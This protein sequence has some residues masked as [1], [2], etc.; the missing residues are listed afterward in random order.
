MSQRIIE[1]AEGPARLSVRHAQLV[2]ERE[3]LD[4]VTTPLE[5]I[6][7][8]VLSAPQ[9]QVTQAVLAGVAAAG[10]ITVISGEKHLPA[11]MVLPLEQHGTQTER[12]AMQAGLKSTVKKRLWQELVAAKIRA[13]GR[14]LKELHGEDGG[15][16]PMAERVRSGDEGNLEAQAARRYWPLLFRDPKFRR[17]SEGPDQNNHLNYGYAVLRAVVARAVCG[18]GLHP[19]LGVAHRNRYNPFCLADDVME[20][21]RPLVDRAAA[22]WV[23]EHD[24]TQPLDKQAKAAMIQPT[25]ARYVAEGEE[26]TLFDVLAGVAG[27]MARV[28]AGEAKRLELPEL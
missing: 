8:L 19:S 27:R 10:G 2:V 1:I 6:A 9:A 26:R 13:Q 15:L 7:A 14:L 5:E 4:T 22:L 25:L 21:F 20:P 3:G 17:G 24:A 16:I 12:F 23:R 18:A 11:G 28:M